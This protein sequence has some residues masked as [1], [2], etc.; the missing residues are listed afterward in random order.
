MLQ[1]RPAPIPREYPSSATVKQHIG[2]CVLVSTS[3]TGS[4]LYREPSS[5]QACFPGFDAH[6][7]RA[8]DEPSKL[9]TS[10][11]MQALDKVDLTNCDRE[12]IHIP[13]RV[14]PHGVLLACDSDLSVV[15]RHSLNAAE[16]LA[17]AF[18][19]HQRP[20]ARRRRWKRQA[21]DVRN[22]LLRVGRSGAPWPD[23]RHAAADARYSV[24]TSPCINT[25]ATPS[26]EFE[27]ADDAGSGRAA[28][29]CARPDRT[30]EPGHRRST[31]SAIGRPL[32]S[33][34][35]RLRPGDDLS[36]RA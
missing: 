14:Q 19:R 21:H 22:A 29:G 33:R 15:R 31:T 13:G 4:A 3:T 8:S 28:G 6:N 23:P 16:T 26:I 18:Q 20:Q 34:H 10:A 24:P 12:P 27:P 11:P 32:S 1:K 25:R 2:T 30:A 35:S 5:L 9:R 36:L 17:P 7:C